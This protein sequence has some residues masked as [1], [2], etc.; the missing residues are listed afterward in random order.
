MSDTCFMRQFT[1]AVR[2]TPDTD[3]GYAV[4]WRDLPEAVT[5]GES[6]QQA[7]AEAAECLEQVIAARIED[8]RDIPEPSAPRRGERAVSV[9]ASMAL[10]A[11]V[12]LAMREAGI[13]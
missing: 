4:A 9:P 6:I 13:S 8:R 12:Y 3:G 7:L 1:Y 10:K 2:L 11:A 5:R